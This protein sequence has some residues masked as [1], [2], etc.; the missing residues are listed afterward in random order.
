MNLGL[1]VVFGLVGLVAFFYVLGRLTPGTGA[2]LLDWDPQG[3]AD[4]RR[5][6][7]D[8]DMQQMLALANRRRRDQGLP[9]LSEYEVERF[10]EERGG[11]G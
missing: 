9:E 10:V 1:V 4:E 5:A 11:L 8:E 2:S 3:R 7:D 6:L